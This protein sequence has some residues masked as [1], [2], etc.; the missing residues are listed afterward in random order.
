M[1]PAIRG[2]LFRN[3]S[4]TFP[5]YECF[6]E[7]GAHSFHCRC[8]FR[9][10]R[11]F[12]AFRRLMSEHGRFMSSTRLNLSLI[13]VLS[14]FVVTTNDRHRMRLIEF[15]E[16]E[17]LYWFHPIYFCIVC[18]VPWGKVREICWVNALGKWSPLA[19]IKR[20]D[21]VILLRCSFHAQLPHSSCSFIV[22]ML[23]FRNNQLRLFPIFE[24][25]IALWLTL[26]HV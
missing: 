19:L 10:W 8:L 16:S 21:C 3:Q 6:I 11:V 22:H 12:H 18:L 14:L 20:P 17:L 7:Y 1:N 5:N 26:F 24:I 23:W 9:S 13:C 4:M 15:S 2:I 25:S